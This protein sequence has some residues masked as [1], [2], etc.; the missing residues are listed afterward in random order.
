[1]TYGIPTCG[2]GYTIGQVYTRLL[3]CFAF[4]P[5]ISLPPSL[6]WLTLRS[7]TIRYRSGAQHLVRSTRFEDEGLTIPLVE[8]TTGEINRLVSEFEP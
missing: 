7:L 4:T 2:L 5:L 6:M 1:M 8:S 3:P